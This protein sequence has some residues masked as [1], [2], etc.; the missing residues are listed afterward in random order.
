MFRNRGATHP[1]LSGHQP[2]VVRFAVS[3]DQCIYLMLSQ[4]L[5][6][7]APFRVLQPTGAN[8]LLPS[9]ATEAVK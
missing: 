7:S 4:L 2:H 9:R 1:E 6:Y 3:G 8:A 5:R